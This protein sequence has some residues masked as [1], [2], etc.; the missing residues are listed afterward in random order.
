MLEPENIDT[1]IDK[2]AELGDD[3]T[4]DFMRQE[5]YYRQIINSVTPR[6]NKYLGIRAVPPELE[7]KTDDGP[8]AQTGEKD[9][10]KTV[11]LRLNKK[12]G[13]QKE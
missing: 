8:K 7:I 12:K 13:F 2:K 6:L 9:G 4:T 10:K 5:A 11:I 3:Q 1:N